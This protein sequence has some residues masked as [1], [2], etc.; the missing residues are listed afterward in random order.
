MSPARSS[1]PGGPFEDEPAPPPGKLTLLEA[2][3]GGGAPGARVDGRG[4]ASLGTRG[5]AP[6]IRAAVQLVARR[7]VLGDGL[8]NTDPTRIVTRPIHAFPLWSFSQFVFALP[9]P[10]LPFGVVWLSDFR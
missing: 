8:Q 7:C 1:L 10:G 6:E 2:G 4:P 9:T 5:R 3:R